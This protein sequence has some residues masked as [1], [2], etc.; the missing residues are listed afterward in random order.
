MQ[1]ATPAAGAKESA[2]GQVFFDTNL[3]SKDGTI[4]LSI[5]AFSKSG[6]Q[7]A[8]GVSKSGSDWFK[9]YFRSTSSPLVPG[10]EDIEGGSGRHEDVLDHVKFSGATWTHDDAGI[11][12]QTYPPTAKDDAGTETDANVDAKLWYHRMGTNQKD[13]ICVIPADPQVPTSMWA[14]TVSDD[15]HWLIVQNPKDTDT[16]Q[17][18]FLANI[19][20]QKIG[21]KMGW[22]HLANKFEFDLSYLTNDG[23][24]FYFSKFLSR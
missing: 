24:R 16:K 12:Y 7:F 18:V 9:I 5:T 1:R 2:G 11:F 19:E 17:R 3:L 10:G 14:P 13:D 8:Y 22:I 23:N 4:A 6:K 21:D 20:N 15:G